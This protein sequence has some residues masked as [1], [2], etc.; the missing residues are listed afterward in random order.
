MAFAALLYDTGRRA[1]RR[2]G[3]RGIIS[4]RKTL[5]EDELDACRQAPRPHDGIMSSTDPHAFAPRSHTR[6]MQFVVR[7]IWA[8]RTAGYRDRD[9]GSVAC[10][11]SRAQF[12]EIRAAG[13]TKTR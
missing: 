11:R 6:L 4:H 12:V 8:R 13:A 3:S 7:I 1:S 2:S 5:T 9:T 10:W